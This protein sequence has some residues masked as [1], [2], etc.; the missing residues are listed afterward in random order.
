M[1]NLLS[2]KF[3]QVVVISKADMPAEEKMDLEDDYI[4]QIFKDMQSPIYC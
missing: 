4:D 1:S 2:K 3:D